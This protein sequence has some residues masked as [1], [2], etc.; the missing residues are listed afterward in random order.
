MDLISLMPLFAPLALDQVENLIDVRLPTGQRGRPTLSAGTRSE[1]YEK[2]LLRARDELLQDVD[3]AR[4]RV[5]ELLDRE[6]RRSGRLSKRW[7]LGVLYPEPLMAYPERLY[8]WH[9][10]GFLFF[11]EQGNLEP[12]SVAALL[13]QRELD[14]RERRKLPPVRTSPQSF[15][16]WRQDKLALTPYP[17]EIPLVRIETHRKIEDFQPRFV[18]EATPYV[19]W[20]PWKGIV[21]GKEE[22]QWLLTEEG[23][24]GWIGSASDGLIAQW[25]TAQELDAVASTIPGMRAEPLC[26]QALVV[27][28]KKRLPDHAVTRE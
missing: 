15:F 6:L 12:Q 13:L 5:F 9:K 4:Q 17:Y 28:M 14:P 11:D 26:K 7:L 10:E 2:R 22:E 27:L 20:V 16:C 24:I 8:E 23:A 19:V 3:P 1:R 18:E 21:W 25:V